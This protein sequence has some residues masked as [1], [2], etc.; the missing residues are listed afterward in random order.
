ME[1]I[2]IEIVK[3]GN[4]EQCRELCNEHGGSIH[5]AGLRDVGA[6]ADEEIG[7]GE[8]LVHLAAIDLPPFH[9]GEVPKWS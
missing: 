2:N 9:R 5:S 7:A 4:I 1:H 6:V 8:I 3:G